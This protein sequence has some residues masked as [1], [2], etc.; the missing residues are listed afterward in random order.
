MA[1]R[2][3]CGIAIAL[4][5]ILFLF[6][7]KA[8]QAVPVPGN[9]A[10]VPRSFAVP[11][12][13]LASR[14]PHFR[15]H[16]ANQR[17]LFAR[18][19]GGT[20]SHRHFW[21]R[22][23]HTA[24]GTVAARQGPYPRYRWPRSAN[25]TPPSATEFPRNPGGP[26]FPRFPRRPGGPGNWAWGGDWGNEPRLP[27]PPSFMPGQAASTASTILG[28]GGNR[29]PVAPRFTG[30]PGQNP[31][32]IASALLNNK[33]HRP[34]ELLVEVRSD[35]R[36][37]A[38]ESFAQEYGVEIKELGV[39]GLAGVRVWHLTMTQGQDQNL[40]ELLTAL[41]QDGRVL[42]A[43]PNYIYTPVQGAPEEK[44]TPRQ[45]A[46]LS[47]RTGKQ[48]PTGM[49]V[50]LAVIDTCV[51]RDHAELQGSVVSSFDAVRR[52]SGS[53]KPEDHGTA[54]ASLIA[55]HYKLRGTAEGASLLSAQAFTFPSEENEIAAT[56]REIA[57]A[58][59]WAAAEG[60]QVMN[61]SFAGPADPL[62]ERVVAAAYRKGIDLV[63]AA[64]NAGPA[65]PPLYPAA[66]PEVIAVTA[67]NG[68]RQIYSAANRGKYI[69]VSARG[70]DVLAAHVNNTY[71]MESG[72]S[73]AAAEVSGVVASLLE[74][75]PKA[76]P[77]EI[78]AALQET[79]AAVPGV[80]R[81][82]AGFGQV[83]PAAAVAFVE[84]SLPQ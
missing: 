45:G 58:M 68:K 42:T 83:N 63:A 71:G 44:A 56:S 64:G 9:G 24:R 18:R 57:L 5:T 82:E 21:T 43:Q 25:R 70:V 73:F 53:C 47:P 27:P 4:L 50:K 35:M 77:E 40:R 69:S 38:K 79:A 80:D 65:S 10:S 13:S 28:A 52:V 75:R 15:G 34:R 66:Y 81:N 48:Q 1:P 39:I 67:T 59:D 22:N 29:P 46:A 72:T 32:Q 19:P 51:E 11:V 26:G 84:T 61:L 33:R 55:G 30:A 76:G 74:K 23:L 6:E 20:G 2:L 54:V 31:A 3:T 41:L 7:P 14:R 78:R 17:H 62:I 60:A 16:F 8:A 49:G 12:Y 37:S 36:D